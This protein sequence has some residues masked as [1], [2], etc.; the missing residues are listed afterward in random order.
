M[1]VRDEINGPAAVALDEGCGRA[2]EH[3]A[4]VKIA[5]AETDRYARPGIMAFDQRAAAAY[6]G[7]LKARTR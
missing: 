2:G 7:R 5:A 1:V 6:H 4:R 3:A